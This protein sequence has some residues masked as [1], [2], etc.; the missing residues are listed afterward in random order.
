MRKIIQFLIGFILFLIFISN[1][2]NNIINKIEENR[3][4]AHEEVYRVIQDEKNIENTDVYI[5]FLKNY[6]SQGE[7]YY[8]S[9]IELDSYNYPILLLSDGTYKD[10]NSQNVAMCTDVYYPIN[11]NVTLFGNICSNGTAYPIS[12]NTTGIYTAGGHEVTKYNLDIH[13]L[14]L[15][16]IKKHK[17][18]I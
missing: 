12:A 1:L 3:R 8:Y 5:E 14:R 11:Y 2:V 13:I 10:E 7:E 17:D 16:I 4:N 6:A 18:D 9:L 15:K